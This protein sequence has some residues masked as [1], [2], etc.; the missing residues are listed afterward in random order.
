VFL[1]I[2]NALEGSKMNERVIRIVEEKK[3]RGILFQI[4]ETQYEFGRHYVL[5]INGEQGFHSTDLE[6][7]QNYMNRMIID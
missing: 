2:L 6:R 7:V 5:V 3:S 1:A 4:A